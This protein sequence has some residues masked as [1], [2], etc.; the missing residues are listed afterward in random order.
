MTLE[1][2]D[3]QFTWKYIKCLFKEQESVV[4]VHCLSILEPEIEFDLSNKEMTR[5]NRWC[6]FKIDVFK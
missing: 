5:I 6:E 3:L 1:L 2:I 4:E